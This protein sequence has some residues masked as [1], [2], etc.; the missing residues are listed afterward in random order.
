MSSKLEIGYV[1]QEVA[2]YAVL[3]WHYSERMPNGKL[4]RFGVKEDGKFIGAVIYGSGANNNML[5]PYG[6]K[7]TEGCELVRVALCKH[8]TP[9]SRIV[10]ITLKMLKKD[11]PGLRLVVSYADTRQN[12]VGTIYQAM[13]WVFTGKIKTTPDYFVGGKWIHQRTLNK[14]YGG[15]TKFEKRPPQRDGGLRLRYLYPLDQDM[16]EQI[17]SLRKPY[18]KNALVV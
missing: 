3:H 7:H 9:V 11:F 17:E 14:V 18:E 1:N 16:R 2:K 8:K 5:K 6:L 15:I 4:I 10:A 12:H 13:N